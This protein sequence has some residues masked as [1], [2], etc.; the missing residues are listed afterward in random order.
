MKLTF[1]ILCL[2]H[3]IL[4]LII[5]IYYLNFAFQPAEPQP[6][7]RS[8]ED[9]RVEAAHSAL[10]HP[11]GDH[12]T[13]LHIF[14]E[15]ERASFSLDWCEQNYINHRTMK[16]VRKIRFEILPFIYQLT[17]NIIIVHHQCYY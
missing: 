15:W 4:M 11:L 8:A 9:E 1:R 2:F 3:F 14:Q 13:Y 16:T 17:N 12:F 6:R 10:R 5:F 7:Y